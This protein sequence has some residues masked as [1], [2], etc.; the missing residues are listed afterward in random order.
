MPLA[1]TYDTRWRNDSISQPS[2][3][4]RSHNISLRPVTRCIPPQTTTQNPKPESAW[5]PQRGPLDY[6]WGAFGTKFDSKF[7]EH[8]CVICLLFLGPWLL[9]ETLCRAFEYVWY[10]TCPNVVHRNSLVCNGFCNV[11]ST[12]FQPYQYTHSQLQLSQDIPHLVKFKH[13]TVVCSPAFIPSPPGSSVESSGDQIW[14]ICSSE[15]GDNPH[16]VQFTHLFSAPS[17][18]AAQIR[19]RPFHTSHLNMS[20]SSLSQLSSPLAGR[21]SRRFPSG[22]AWFTHSVP[23][24]KRI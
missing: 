17:K 16:T 6:F 22:Q 13:V 15:E 1:G 23:P 11:K 14:R 4:W 21:K 7:R 5:G 9:S 24:S 3:F 12:Q 19:R 18:L 10:N 20:G 2:Q 8:F